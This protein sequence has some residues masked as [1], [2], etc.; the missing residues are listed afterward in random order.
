MIPVNNFRFLVVDSKNQLFNFPLIIIQ[1]Q[2]QF[3]DI[4]T[5]FD[6]RANHVECQHS[7]PFIIPILLIQ[8]KPIRLGDKLYEELIAMKGMLS[9]AT[10]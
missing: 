5:F 10:K 2:V 7:F 6:I 9:K 8:L 3:L 1:L 4:I